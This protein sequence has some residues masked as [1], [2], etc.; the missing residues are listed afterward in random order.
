MVSDQPLKNIN[1][2]LDGIRIQVIDSVQYCVDNFGG[3]DSAEALFNYLKSVTEFQHD[4]PRVELIQ[5]A[6]TLFE[7]NQLGAPGRGDCD[8]FVVLACGS[9]I[10][11]GW[12]DFDIIL[13]GRSKVYPVHIYTAVNDG[14][15]YQIFDLT[16][17]YIGMERN[18]PLKQVLPIKFHNQ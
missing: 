12:K 5:T 16:N 9:F 4:P 14:S 10:A 1:Q 15:G 11:N 13:T 6:K 8:D 18:Y 7:N 17:A 2:V 3:F